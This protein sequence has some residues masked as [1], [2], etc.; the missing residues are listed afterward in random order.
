MYISDP[1]S[2]KALYTQWFTDIY[3]VLS[4][5][6]QGM[7]YPSVSAM[8]HNIVARSPLGEDTHL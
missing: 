3:S 7:P 1:Y 8:P 2:M 4:S 6:C 5:Y